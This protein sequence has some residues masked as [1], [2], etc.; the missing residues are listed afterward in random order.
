MSSRP[1]RSSAAA[2]SRRTASSSV[3]SASCAHASPPSAANQ[4]HRV[5]RGCLV[6]I[7]DQDAS[8]LARQHHRHRAPVADR[9]AGGLP[10]AHDD[11][12]LA[13][14]A[15]GHRCPPEK[16]HEYNAPGGRT[17]EP[18]IAR[19]S[20]AAGR[21]GRVLR[22][23]PRDTAERRGPRSGR[24]GRTSR[25]VHV[26]RRLLVPDH[27]ERHPRPSAGSTRACGSS[28]PST[29]TRP[30]RRS[31]RARAS[32]PACA[33]CYW[34]IA[35]TE[36]SNYNHPTDA[37]RE[38]R[39]LAAVQAG[40]GA[41]SRRRQ[42]RGARADPGHRQAPLG[43]S[44][45]PSAPTLDRA[46]ADAMREVARQFPDDLEA[47]TFFADAMMNLRPWNLWTPDGSAAAGHRGD[48]R[49]RSSACSPGI[50]TIRARSTSTSTRSRP[51]PRARAR[52]GR[53]RPS[54][55][56]D[57]RAPATSVHMPSHIYW[58]VGRYADAVAVNVAAVQADRAYFKTAQPSPIYRGLYYPH[59]IDFIWQSASMQGRSAETCAPPASSRTNA[60]AE[61]I[62][63]DAGHGD[64]AGRADRG[65]RAL[66]PVGRGARASRRPRR[67]WL[68]TTRR[69][70]L[71]AR[72]GVQRQGPG[73]RGRARA[74]R[75]GGRCSSRCRR[76]APSRSSSAPRTCC[77]SR[78]TCWPARWRPRPATSAS[79]ERLLR[80]AVAEQDTHWFTEPPPWYF[81]VRQSLGAVLLQAGRAREAEQ[82]YREDLRRNPGNGW[83]LFG[84]TR[85]L[86][87]QGK[88]AE[89]GADRGSASARRG[90]R[91]TCTLTAS[92]F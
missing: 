7:D 74:G 88:T 92:R 70:A 27:D 39:A 69:V 76:S 32:I 42:P 29:T 86:R 48:R 26:A 81:P 66:R 6:T 83:S 78:P 57:A 72:P 77:S 12:R 64:G 43:R 21:A 36:G 85:S 90:R 17:H 65:A 84:L 24:R 11:R 68:Y 13:L 67:E 59:N 15:P 35:I 5:L 33:M 34:G 45:R 87:A 56:A 1:K 79:A 16:S 20:A 10:A 53:R 38:K 75:A 44:R 71:R 14:D 3:M 22:S 31:G 2:T 82:V 55:A 37:D 8:A 63:A 54:G 40:P 19:V 49:R 47:A 73:R 46:Y 23:A 50:P 80:A 61:M 25:R 28:T 51:S 62:K 52:R 9:L 18:S 60:P 30:R 91:P 4:L 89:A 58:R 41:R